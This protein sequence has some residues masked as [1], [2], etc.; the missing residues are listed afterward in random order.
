MNI[1]IR[2]TVRVL[3]L[4]SENSLL[5]MCIEGLDIS[6]PDGKKLH[7]FW[8][9]IGGTQKANESIEQTAL[10]EIYEESGIPDSDIILGPI[11]W[12][13]T[14]HM[15]VKG[16][17]TQYNETFIV[18]KTKRNNVSLHNLTCD[19]KK[20]VKKIQWF[21]LDDIKNI[22]EKIFPAQLYDYLSD[23]I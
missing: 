23:I 2:K 14:I 22:S 10:R 20:V 19:E 8:Q 11:V 7:R 13:G 21:A 18:A 6:T 5:L 9:T 17:L 3:L 4:N 15:I 16:I 12:Q 1:P